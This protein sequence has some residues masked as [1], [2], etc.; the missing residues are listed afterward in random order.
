[1]NADD[2]P[3]GGITEDLA[4]P[5]EFAGAVIQRLTS[6]HPH[7]FI[8]DQSRA[9]LWTRFGLSESGLRCALEVLE[10]ASAEAAEAPSGPGEAA[11]RGEN[12]R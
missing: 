6:C 11:A 3:L 2:F 10:G 1:M 12:D 9:P 5:P 8:V 4:V 7:V